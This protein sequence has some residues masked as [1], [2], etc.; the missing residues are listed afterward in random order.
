MCAR[1]V[2]LA[3]L[4]VVACAL[5]LSGAPTVVDALLDIAADCPPGCTTPCD[6]EREGKGCPAGRPCGCDHSATRVLAVELSSVLPETRLSETELPFSPYRAGL[7]P[8]PPLASLYR[9][10][11]G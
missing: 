10:P 7:P 4:V 9:P 8:S 5:Q 3:R 2:L 1:L 6:D 11:R